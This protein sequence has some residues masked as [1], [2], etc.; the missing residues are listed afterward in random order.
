VYAQGVRMIT[1]SRPGELDRMWVLD[2]LNVVC[3]RSN[4]YFV[5][6]DDPPSP[7]TWPRGTGGKSATDGPPLLA[8][9]YV[10]NRQIARWIEGE[11][12]RHGAAIQLARTVGEVVRSLT[13]DTPR[14]DLM[15]I[16]IAAI[17]AAQLLELHTV[18]DGWAGHIIAVGRLTPAVRASLGINHVLRPPFVRDLLRDLVAELSPLPRAA[19]KVE[20]VLDGPTRRAR[21]PSAEAAQAPPPRRKRS[22]KATTPLKRR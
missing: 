22:T 5:A 13:V 2:T 18:R 8:V 10:S 17:T 21:R 1:R 3:N 20:P 19:S 16:D 7:R 6:R 4:D 12:S 11:L 15:I 14:P 9:V